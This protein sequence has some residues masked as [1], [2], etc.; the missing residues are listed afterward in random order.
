MA[1]A[2]TR[3][4]QTRPVQSLV[5]EYEWFHTTVGILGNL[6]FFVG[7]IF[8]LFADLKTVGTWL[9]IIGSF[10][11][12]IGALGRALVDHIEEH[13]PEPAASGH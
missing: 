13:H 4:E 10:G 12:L 3:L 7:S 5:R 6:T 11:M 1:S 2:M 8:F 9:F